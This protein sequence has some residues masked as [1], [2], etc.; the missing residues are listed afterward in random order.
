MRECRRHAACATG[1]Q[2]RSI[3]E[4]GALSQ[5]TGFRPDVWRGQFTSAPIGQRVEL[6]SK[7]QAPVWSH[8][9]WVHADGYA[10][11]QRR[12]N[13]SRSVRKAHG[14]RALRYV[15][16]AILERKFERCVCPHKVPPLPR[17]AMKADCAIPIG[18]E[19]N[20]GKG[21][22]CLPDRR[23]VNVLCEFKHQCAG[24]Q[25]PS[26]DLSGRMVARP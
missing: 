20:N 4:P 5:G 24:L 3:G 15:D 19:S 12:A 8:Q 1:A 18:V 26:R 25:H 23:L 21:P 2:R 22:G 9:G 14:S 16:P 13:S 17:S 11:F 10:A 7:R 6:H